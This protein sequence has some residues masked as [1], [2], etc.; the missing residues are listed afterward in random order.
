ML[1]HLLV[2]ADRYALQG[3]QLI[4]EDKLCKY[5]NVGTVA[6]ILALAEQHHCH[7]LKKACFNFLSSAANLRAVVA[8]EGFK[9]LSRSCPSITEQL[10]AM[11]GNFVP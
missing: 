2:P 11:L 4:C 1:Q 6:T 10:I 5:I 3:L 9:H 8:N 7:G